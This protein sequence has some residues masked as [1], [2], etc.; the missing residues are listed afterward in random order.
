MRRF[1]LILTAAC[2]GAIIWP[3]LFGVRSRR[4]IAAAIVVAA[5][6]TQLIIEGPRWQLWP[7]YLVA[8]GLAVGDLLSIERVLPWWRRVSRPTLGL[9]GLG[10]LTL[11][12]A[13]L[14]VPVLPEPGG[15]LAV[16]TQTVE[17]EFTDRLEPY[18]PAPD[19]V[20]RRIMVQ[21][22]YPA[23][24]SSADP[25]AWSSDLDIVGP[26]LSGRMG[27]PG[28][29][30]S[31][32][33][34]TR[35]HSSPG[36]EPLSGRFPVVLYS[37]GWAEF[38]ALALNQLESLASRGYMVIAPDHRYAAL[39]T[40]NSDGTISEL[41]PAA[42]PARGTVDE[43]SYREAAIDLV[44]VLT[45][46][47]AGILTELADGEAFGGLAAHADLGRVGVFG[48]GAGGGATVRL[49]LSDERCRAA[50]GQDPWV[51]VVPDRVIAEP[52]TVPM[53]FMRSDEARGTSNDGR[54]RG[55]AERS[56]ATTYWIGI[57]GAE[58]N[59][60]LLAPLLSPIGH[61]LGI[62]GPIAAGVIVPI[63]DRF[64]VGFFDHTLLGTGPAAIENNPFP[65]VSLEVIG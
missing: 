16:G 4:G 46:D 1:E 59:D 30:L 52:A 32:T 20:P 44:G 28:F 40:R 10:M 49:C 2:A 27:F 15:E 31:H 11:L 33:R 51:E 35:A 45:D 36:A 60:F 25:V 56:D 39:A 14:P 63:I 43:E 61:R 17:V 21:V 34:Y 38:R 62:K 47:L 12:P 50:L 57:A 64:L 42:L 29:F 54:L 65:E 6:A 18:G 13:A 55:L 9:I 41:D 8:S 58:S 3:A 19:T 7:L 5:L 24:A 23:V 26:R 48:H 22:W 37:H 53:L